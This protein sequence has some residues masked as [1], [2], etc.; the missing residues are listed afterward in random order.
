MGS[1][2]RVRLSEFFRGADLWEFMAL[3]FT[4]FAKLSERM[5]IGDMFAI[6]SKQIIHFPDDRHRNVQGIANFAFRNIA[7][8]KIKLGEIQTALVHGERSK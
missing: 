3:V 6:P 7:S 4:E 2:K 1:S 5:R 8:F